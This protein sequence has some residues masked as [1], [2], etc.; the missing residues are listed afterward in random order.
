MNGLLHLGHAFS[1]SKVGITA[2][3]MQPACFA[4]KSAS[5]AVLTHHA[6]SACR[7]DACTRCPALPFCTVILLVHS[8]DLQGWTSGY[9]AG[10]CLADRLNISNLENGSN[11]ELC[12][13]CT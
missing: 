11:A 3:S 12:T 10:D 13:G 8:Q 1:L 7:S 4:K 9:A 6:I 5:C 2:G